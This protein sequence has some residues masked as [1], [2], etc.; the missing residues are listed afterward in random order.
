MKVLL[1][2]P[3]FLGEDEAERHIMRPYPPLGLLYISAHL[4]KQQSFDVKIFDGTFADT[5]AFRQTL[6]Q[7]EPQVIGFYANMMTRMNLIRLHRLVPEETV[8]VV[9]GPDVR[10]YI[11]EYL[12]L[13]IDAAVVGEG[14][15]TLVSL[16]HEFKNKQNWGNI[17]GIAFIDSESGITTV[18]P[19]VKP[20]RDLTLYGMPDRQAI[21]LNQYLD[22]WEHHHG[23][24]PISLI[25]SRGCPFQCTWCAHH[26][27]GYSLRKRPVDHVIEELEWLSENYQF[28]HYWFA[29]D[30]FTIQPKW[31]AELADR[32]AERPELLK[33]FECI[34]RAD[35]LDTTVISHLARL[36]C[37][38]V[39]VGAESGSQRLLDL[40]KR[41][42]TREQVFTSV[43]ELKKAG[44]DTGMFFMWGF[45]N[46][47]L[48]DVE[49]TIELAT[50]CRTD[51]ALTTIAY[52]IKGT[53]FY[54]SLEEQGRIGHVPFDEGS[55]RQIT[56]KGQRSKNTYDWASKLLQSKLTIAK[57]SKG[58]LKRWP[59]WMRSKY[60][61]WRL[62]WAWQRDSAV[63]SQRRDSSTNS[64]IV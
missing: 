45:E 30:V 13:G 37:S 8:T 14:E 61:G 63:P 9:G 47:S 25:T 39:W 38:R 27:F 1:V 12:S 58:D 48:E 43:T 62:A 20:P 42:V 41:G 21:N 53:P 40:M 15:H 4:K 22:C 17:P 11:D 64:E 60:Y 6:K 34:S 10:H 57:Q 3:Y 16:L 33:P 35:K 23:M 26:V 59:R 51:L 7:F 31:T 28:D 36:K 29:D 50:S 54:K 18:N 2:H 56:I 5:E 46:E 55:D 19:D 52:P 24:R 32:L 44:I 49:E